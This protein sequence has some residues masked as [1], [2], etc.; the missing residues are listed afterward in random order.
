[1]HQKAYEERCIALLKKYPDAINTPK[2]PSMYTPFLVRAVVNELLSFQVKF[3]VFLF[4]E[5][6]VDEKNHYTK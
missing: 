4:F 6:L 3:T 2:P 5:V 1:M